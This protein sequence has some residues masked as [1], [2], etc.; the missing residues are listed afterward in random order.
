LTPSKSR[1]STA[2]PAPQLGDIGRNPPRFI[3]GE[4]AILTLAR[5][6]L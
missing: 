3:V 4:Q 2:S 6:L 5:Y 1:K